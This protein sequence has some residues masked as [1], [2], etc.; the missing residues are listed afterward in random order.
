MIQKD[1]KLPKPSEY[2]DEVM[3]EKDWDYYFECRA[4]YDKPM[5]HEEVI[6]LL[7][8]TTKLDSTYL[9][10]PDMQ[11]YLDLM[12]TMPV[13]PSAA[14]AVKHCQGFKALQ[15]FNLY[16]AKKEYPDEF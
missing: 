8:K 6:K 2:K 4:K 7:E 3:T 16:D 5:S 12:Q 11:T 10:S 13:T 15:E 1:R 9:D 14:L